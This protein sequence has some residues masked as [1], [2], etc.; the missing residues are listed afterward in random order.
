MISY[1]DNRHVYRKIEIGNIFCGG[2]SNIGTLTITRIGINIIFHPYQ[3]GPISSCGDCLFVE[4]TDISM[5]PFAI[6]IYKT[7]IDGMKACV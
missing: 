2:K 5:A 6:G 3:V 4:S 1:G 7:G